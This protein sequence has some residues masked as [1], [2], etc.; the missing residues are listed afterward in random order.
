MITNHMLG[1]QY[2]KLHY[3]C[4]RNLLKDTNPKCSNPN[5]LIYHFP[6]INP[7]SPPNYQLFPIKIPIS[8][9]TSF[10]YNLNQPKTHKNTKSCQS[11]LRRM[12]GVH[13]R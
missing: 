3:F 10:S 7:N 12:A 6:P 2:T 8:Q 5:M 4:L 9:K 11:S 1:L 13:H